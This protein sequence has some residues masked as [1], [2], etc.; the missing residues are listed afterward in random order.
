MK[1]N[2]IHL[3]HRIDRLEILTKEL[4]EQ[5]ISDYQMWDGII[6]AELPSRGISKAHKQ[7]IMFAKNEKLPEVLPSPQGFFAVMCVGEEP[8]GV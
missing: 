4:Q 1:L 5:Q 7:I 6:D 3:R 8:C 2:I